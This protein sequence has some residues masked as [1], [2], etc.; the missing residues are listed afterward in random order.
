M[1]GV[2]TFVPTLMVVMN[3]RVGM[4]LSWEKTTGPVMVSINTEQIHV[5]YSQM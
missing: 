5:H 3:V 4:G 2:V 1:V